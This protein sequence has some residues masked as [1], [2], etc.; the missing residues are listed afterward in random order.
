MGNP[1]FG[2]MGGDLDLRQYFIRL[3]VNLQSVFV[4]FLTVYDPLSLFSHEF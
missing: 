2:G 3:E 4:K 1:V